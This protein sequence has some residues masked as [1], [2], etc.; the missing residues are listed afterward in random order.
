MAGELKLGYNTGYWAGGPPE[1]VTEAIAEAEKLGFDSMWTAEA[2]GSDGLTPLAWW[3]SDTQ[4]LKLGTAITQMSARQPAATAMAAMTMDHLSGGRFIL[5][6]GVSGPQV[7]EGWY[8]MPFAKPLARTREY[9]GILRDIWARKGPVTSD[10]EHYPLPLPGGTGLGKPLKAS[11]HPL[12]EDIPIYLGA[13]GPKNIALAAEL[14]DGWLAMLFDP[15]NPG[16]FE[17]ALNEGFSREGA[18]R[19][20]DDFEVAATV[21]LLITD[22]IEAAADVLRPF[23]ALYFGGMG[24]KGKNFHA[25]VAIRMGYEEM[26][27]KV[28]DLYLDGKRDEAGAAIPTELIEKLSLIGPKEKIREDIDAWRESLVTTLLVQGDV[29]LVRDAADLVL[30]S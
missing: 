22:D 18:R 1:G 23:Y 14:C 27:D 10:G 28:A 19:S 4:K 6:L 20:K 24:A 3:G 11:I 2:Y 30:G 26:V 17:E 16:Y 8:G 25:N 21:P 29:N 13:E 5:G 12:R 9:I 15:R 7:V